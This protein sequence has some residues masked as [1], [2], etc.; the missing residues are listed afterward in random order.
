M[1][2]AMIGEYRI[3]RDSPS[4]DLGPI[5]RVLVIVP[6]MTMEKRSRFSQQ[7]HREMKYTFYRKWEVLE[8]VYDKMV[9]FEECQCCAKGNDWSG[10]AEVGEEGTS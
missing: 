10:H 4:I 7:F 9:E 1:M 3:L 8:G 6:W 5:G 2:L